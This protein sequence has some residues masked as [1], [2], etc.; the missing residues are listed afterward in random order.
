MWNIWKLRICMLPASL[1]LFVV[2]IA[3]GTFSN[4]NE[5]N[6]LFK[7]SY[8]WHFTGTAIPEQQPFSEKNTMLKCFWPQERNTRKKQ[9]LKYLSFLESAQPGPPAFSPLPIKKLRLTLKTVLIWGFRQVQLLGKLPEACLQ[10][11]LKI[12]FDRRSKRLLPICKGLEL[13]YN[14]GSEPMQKWL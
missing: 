6:R 13:I 4:Q 11:N 12:C 14:N 1:A 2:L 3:K 10:V 8:N 7:T 5:P 9:S